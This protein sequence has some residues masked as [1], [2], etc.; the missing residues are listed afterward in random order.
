MVKVFGVSK[1]GNLSKKG[2]EVAKILSKIDG[3][4]LTYRS[5]FHLYRDIFEWVTVTTKTKMTG[6][7]TTMT[8]IIKRGVGSSRELKVKRLNYNTYNVS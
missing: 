4:F 2:Q 5:P 3:I 1:I 6:K 8:V 7:I